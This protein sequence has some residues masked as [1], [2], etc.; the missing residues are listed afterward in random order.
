MNGQTFGKQGKSY[1]AG[2][3]V[4]REHGRV[5]PVGGIIDNAADFA[6]QG[7]VPAGSPVTLTRFS[8]YGN[9]LHVL[10]DAELDAAVQG[11]QVAGFL[12]YDVV[13]DNGVT[14]ENATGA[15]C[16]EGVLYVDRLDIAITA[17]QRKAL[18]AVLP[19]I[20]LEPEVPETT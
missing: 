2:R 10:K 18:K 8:E 1:K 14:P 16:V 20:Y 17:A 15:V 4:W 12:L 6:D 9:T 7:Y 3:Q 5:L 19:G 11:G 13:F